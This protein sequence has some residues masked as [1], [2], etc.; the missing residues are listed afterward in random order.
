MR[1]TFDCESGVF[2][3]HSNS[4]VTLNI[5]PRLKIKESVGLIDVYFENITDAVKET[6]KK[7][8]LNE[9]N[10][11]IVTLPESFVIH[12]KTIPFPASIAGKI[13]SVTDLPNILAKV[14]PH[15]HLRSMCPQKVQ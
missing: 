15:S 10:E 2:V 9:M 6:L 3:L 11:K 5:D 14:F 1:L 8:L 12:G 4:D 13:F 7:L